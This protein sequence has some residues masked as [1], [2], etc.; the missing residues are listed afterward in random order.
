LLE[1]NIA[2]EWGEMENQ[3]SDDKRAQI[4]GDVEVWAQECQKHPDYKLL[5]EEQQKKFYDISR[6]FA[7]TMYS[8]YLQAPE[9]WTKSALHSTLTDI[10]PNKL[11]VQ[12]A[13]AKDVE[14][15]LTVLL[16]YL[17]S[18][19]II[20]PLNAQNLREQLKISTSEMPLTY[21]KPT[22]KERPKKQRSVASIMGVNLE[23][24]SEISDRGYI[25]QTNTI[26]EA[27]SEG[28]TE[29]AESESQYA[30][31]PI[32]NRRCTCG[33]GKKYK[34]CC[35]PKTM[36]TNKREK[37]DRSKYGTISRS[38]TDEPT[39]AQWSKLYDITQKIGKLEPWDFLQEKHFITLMLPG[40]KEPVYCA[41]IGNA[42]RCFGIGI[43]P[44][45]ESLGALQRLYE[46]DD[47]IRFLNGLEQD[48]IMCYFGDNKELTTKEREILKKLNLRFRGHNQY[49]Y[50][51]SM[52]PGYYPWHINAEQAKLAIQTLQNFYMA[53]MHLLSEKFCVN[54]F[55]GNTLLR[56]YSPEKK[57]W[58]NTA[59]EMPPVPLMR[60]RIIINDDNL[61]AEMKGKKRTRAKLEF[62]ITYLTSPVEEKKGDR[63][64]FPRLF[65]LVD[66]KDG[67]P[68]DQHLLHNDDRLERSKI[69]LG[70]LLEYISNFGRPLSINVR[71]DRVADIIADF[72]EKI[73]VK[74]IAGQGIPNIDNILET[75]SNHMNSDPK[76]EYF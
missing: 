42:G 63:P 51:R 52:T 59:I 45:Y 1:L 57:L 3:Y 58:I 68:L 64:Y 22:A 54:F 44:G 29:D 12:I 65:L 60:Q 53:C 35:M 74:L 67:M 15:V 34:K 7:E 20:D 41:V 31:K 43:Y 2:V 49:I 19:C 50:F 62:E 5:S 71:D 4:C 6:L 17:Q 72:C 47:T 30:K 55:S 73:G 13:Y 14:P 25:T 38:E 27:K 36:N 39:L 46:L 56:Q 37:V 26:E 16:R 40:R 33:S 48:C 75:L 10:Y 61:I 24:A 69:G 18:N 11:L 32:H 66:K 76:E 23:G 8:Y 9:Q 28:I 21:E 70:M